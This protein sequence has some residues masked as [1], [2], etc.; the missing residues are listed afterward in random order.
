MLQGPAY[1]YTTTLPLF[2]K[3]GEE[4]FSRWDHIGSLLAVLSRR[5]G[6]YTRT[7]TTPHAPLEGGWLPEPHGSPVVDRNIW[8][9]VYARVEAEGAANPADLFF[10]Y[11]KSLLKKAAYV[12]Q[13]EILVERAH[14]ELLP[15][16]PLPRSPGS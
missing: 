6:G 14:V 7:S 12:K 5:F 2:S 4:V 9:Q 11:L 16:I 1:R 10:G 3:D 15:A 13:D 8:I